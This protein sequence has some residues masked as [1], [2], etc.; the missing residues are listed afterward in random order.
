MFGILVF[1][2]PS[3]DFQA[4]RGA[5]MGDQV[6]DDFEIFQGNALPVARDVAEQFV[7]DLVPFA[8]AGGIVTHFDYKTGGVG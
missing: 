2:Q 6:D 5:R 7:F 1:V 8:G 4:C 3:M